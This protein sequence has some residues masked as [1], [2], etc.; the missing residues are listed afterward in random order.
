MLIF[1]VGGILL[2]PVFFYIAN[3]II[4]ILNADS[5]NYILFKVLIALLYALYVFLFPY[6]YKAIDSKFRS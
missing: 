1:I 2:F 6:I 5:N 4:K 3:E